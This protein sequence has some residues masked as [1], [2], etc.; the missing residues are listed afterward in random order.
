MGLVLVTGP[1]SDPISLAEARAHA[2]VTSDDDDGLIVGY[3]LAARQYIE[4]ITGRALLSKIFDF[5]IDGW[6][7]SAEI[8]LPR[9]PLISVISVSY[10]DTAGATQSLAADQYQVVT[11]DL[12]GR[13]VPAYG[14]TWPQVRSQPESVTV[15]FDAGHG[16]NPGSIPE[17]LRQAVLLLVGYWYDVR[18]AVNIGNT[19]NEM[20]FAVDSLIAPYRVYF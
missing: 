11:S 7:R 13:I 8:E 6:P 14:V 9:V 3:I 4:E 17:A 5:K 19:V 15:R 1:T 18:E 12:I 10:V 2:R 20:P 16:T